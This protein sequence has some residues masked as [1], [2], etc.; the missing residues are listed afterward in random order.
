MA[1]WQNFPA[2]TSPR[3]ANN[4]SRAERYLT[5]TAG[6]N[7]D[8][9]VNIDGAVGLATGDM[10]HISFPS[11]TTATSNAKLSVDN[12]TNYKN[13][14]NLIG[15]Q[16][17]ANYIQSRNLDLIYNGTDFIL[18][19]QNDLLNDG[20]TKVYETWTYASATTITVPSGAASRYRKGDK[21]KLTQTTVK[22]FSIVAVA[23]T[24]LTVT[25]GIDYTVANATITSPYYSHA[26]SPIGFPLYFNFTPTVTATAG[27]IT[28]AS[29]SAR[30]NVI[31]G[32]IFMS[33]TTTLTNKGT[34]TG[35]LKNTL[36]V[37]VGLSSVGAGRENAATAFTIQCLAEGSN[38]VH[39]KYDGTTAL[40]NGWLIIYS[41]HYK[42]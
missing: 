23:D 2:T 9:Y 42:Y 24:L 22:Y 4:L 28:T 1:F 5:A 37:A 33:G 21:I 26:E 3:N 6:S 12:G 32:E 14:K 29:A 34:G 38:V 19:L 16:L 39:S 8:Y 27:T 7:G 10:V 20:W 35:D 36:P 41:I 13:I 25:G 31:G 11:A 15:T 17:L 40:N 18:L 30:F